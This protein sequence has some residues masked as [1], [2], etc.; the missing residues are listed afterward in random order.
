LI[1][2][3]STESVKEVKEILK[4]LDKLVVKEPEVLIEIKAN[5]SEELNKLISGTLDFN[6]R[7]FIK[8]IEVND[9]EKM[10]L[11]L[12]VLKKE[13]AN[14]LNDD[15]YFATFCNGTPE[16]LGLI[17]NALEGNTA[18]L[19]VKVLNAYELKDTAIKNLLQLIMEEPKGDVIHN[20]AFDNLILSLKGEKVS[21]KNLKSHSK[22][23]LIIVCNNKET[24]SNFLTIWGEKV[25]KY[26]FDILGVKAK[27]VSC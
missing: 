14:I 16:M 5:G 21:N 15:E 13:M 26:V 2:S 1:N 9:M 10:K 6:K 17:I 4:R 11:I 27:V 22:D 12:I 25:I 8:C 7:D 20:K 3:Q 23:S 24:F 18:E 19:L